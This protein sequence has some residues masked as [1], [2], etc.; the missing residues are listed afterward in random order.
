[1]VIMSRVRVKIGVGMRVRVTMGGQVGAG[2][3]TISVSEEPPAY[4]NSFGRQ[5]YSM[6]KLERR[7]TEKDYW[8]LNGRDAYV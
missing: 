3:T 1:M 6:R 2:A 8:R 5:C 4:V 7:R